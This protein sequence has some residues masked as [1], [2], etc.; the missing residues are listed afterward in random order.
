MGQ[1]SSWVFLLFIVGDVVLLL[2]SKGITVIED[3]LGLV[4]HP[5]FG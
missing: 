1:L 3:W 5:L 4:R 2:W